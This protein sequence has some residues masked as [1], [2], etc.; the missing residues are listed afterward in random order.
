MFN[1]NRYWFFLL[2][3]ILGYGV[4]EY[5]RPKPLD[6]TS[7]Y[8]NKDKIPL[9]AE[10]IFRLLPEMVGN[11]KV[12]SVRLPPYNQLLTDSVLMVN[13]KVVPYKS[14]YIFINNEF[15]V[16]EN[17][18]K[19][20]LNYVRK[21]NTVFISAY[22]FPDSLMK[23]LGVEAVLDEPSKKDTAKYV[24]FE[25]PVLR[26]KKGSIFTK[27]DGRNHFKI[28]DF[29]KTILL[30]SNEDKQPVFVQ[31]NYGKGQFFLHNL[32]LAFT[33]YFIVDSLTNKHAFK[34]LS[35]LPRQHVYWDEY[36]KQGRFGDDEKS[37][38]RYIVSQPG[39]KTAYF[40]TL[41]GLLLY[42]IFTGKRKQRIIPI[43]KPPGN[44]SLEFVKT[45]G[46]MY[47]RKGDH[48]NM[49]EKQIQYFWIYLRERFGMK[50][51]ELNENEVFEMIALKG[52]MSESDARFL[53]EEITDREGKWT[54][55]RLLDL[56]RKLEGFYE[57]TR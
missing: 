23:V 31:V 9:G 32:P 36:Q 2:L 48:A 55:E 34:A 47:Y 54:G 22:D 52:I 18:E 16:D 33:N 21:G 50:V 8:S 7:T 20:L 4:F 57:R 45:I 5:Y 43:V 12:E 28:T 37:A 25:N 13:G 41:A 56:N 24:N 1:L 40:L 42:A 35:Y 29:S 14:T 49:A 6:W 11:K 46:N 30:A 19:A 15:L 3:M 39:L 38:F 10:L 51:S 27:D 53:K 44:A 17:D 26:E